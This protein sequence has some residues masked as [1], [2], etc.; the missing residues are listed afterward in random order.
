MGEAKILSLE[1]DICVVCISKEFLGSYSCVFSYRVYRHR[2]SWW[3]TEYDAAV[4]TRSSRQLWRVH[5]RK[6]I[7]PYCH[8][9][10]C[11]NIYYDPQANLL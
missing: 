1:C 5:G 9:T 11:D 4:P 3:S 10:S 6:I 8:V 7:A 2:W